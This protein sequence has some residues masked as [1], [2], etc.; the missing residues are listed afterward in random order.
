MEWTQIHAVPLEFERTTF[1]LDISDLKKQR[2]VRAFG[3]LLWVQNDLIN[4][5]YAAGAKYSGAEAA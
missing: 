5:H 2:M 3:K 1:S 4:R